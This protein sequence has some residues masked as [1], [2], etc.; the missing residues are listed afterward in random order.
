MPYRFFEDVA[1][2]DTAFEAT[3]RTVEEMF[4]SAALAVTNTMVRDLASVE[5]K[6]ERKFTVKADSVEMLLFNFLQEVVF[7]KDAENLLFSSFVV[8]VDENETVAE[9]TASGEELDMKKHD[10]VVDVKAVTM[11]RFK[12]EKT[13]DGWK[14]QVILDI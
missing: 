14:S 12:V 2:A 1:I 7:Y 13:K 6:V 11:H 5:R 8:K 4:E 3:G 9:C 10:L